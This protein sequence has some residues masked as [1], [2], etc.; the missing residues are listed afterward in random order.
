MNKRKKEK[1][2]I[3]ICVLLVIQLIVCGI[4]IIHKKS[5][6]KNVTLEMSVKV[7]KEEYNK[8]PDNETLVVICDSLVHL[9][10]IDIINYLESAME[11]DNDELEAILKRVYKN[12]TESL[13]DLD[14]A[15]KYKAFWIANSLAICANENNVEKFI[16]V[17]DGFV[18]KISYKNRSFAIASAHEIFENDF[19][20]KNAYLFEKFFIEQC[21]K[22]ETNIEKLEYLNLLSALYSVSRSSQDKLTD[23]TIEIMDVFEKDN[24]DAEQWN[25][26]RN[27]D[28]ACFTYMFSSAEKNTDQNTGDGSVC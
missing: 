7:L 15:E 22:S 10:D 6:M 21:E 4:L 26:M 11:I 12:Q 20:I 16:S 14:D 19:Y 28:I 2:L 1:L 18:P 24:I 5:Q 8:K 9:K 3:V 25:E 17:L 23:T 27:L 13:N